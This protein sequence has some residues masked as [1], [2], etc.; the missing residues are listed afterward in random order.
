MISYHD[1]IWPELSGGNLAWSAVSPDNIH[2]ND[3]GHRLIADLVTRLLF[4]QP[5]EAVPLK[6][7]ARSA[8]RG[9]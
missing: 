5:V 4:G 1:A 3:V 7:P 6:A 9:I 2:P 8:L